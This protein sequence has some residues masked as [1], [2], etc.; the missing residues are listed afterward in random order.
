MPSWH[1]GQFEEIHEHQQWTMDSATCRYWFNQEGLGIQPHQICS[2]FP[3]P[4]QLGADNARD[5]CF[6]E[7]GAPLVHNG[8]V[9]GIR[10][11]AVSCSNPEVPT[12]STR[13]SSFIEWISNNV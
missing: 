7:P 2:G 6:G 10:S 8:V 5:K 13:V 11:F 3:D 12:A 4:A 9:V 1:P